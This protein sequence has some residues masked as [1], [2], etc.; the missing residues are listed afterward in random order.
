MPFKFVSVFHSDDEFISTSWLCCDTG[1]CAFPPVYGLMQTP[2]VQLVMETATPAATSNTH[3]D[4]SL[5]EEHLALC[6]LYFIV[7]YCRNL[8]FSHT[9]SSSALTTAFMQITAAW[10]WKSTTE[11]TSHFSWHHHD[12]TGGE[13][14]QTCFTTTSLHAPAASAVSYD[15]HIKQGCFSCPYSQINQLGT[16]QL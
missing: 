1:A 5:T 12:G 9:R 2:P 11:T 7:N 6:A 3:W 10:S 15:H 8:S 14:S 16:R 4:K 13:N